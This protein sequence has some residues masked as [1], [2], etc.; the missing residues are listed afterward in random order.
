ME[1]RALS[2]HA[3]LANSRGANLDWRGK[4]CESSKGKDKPVDTDP[5]ITKTFAL[6]SSHTF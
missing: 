5:V 6:M 3:D 1:S 4:S 2:S